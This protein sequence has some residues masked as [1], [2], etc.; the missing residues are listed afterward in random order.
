MK[1]S[2]LDL[3]PVLFII[4][5]ND[6]THPT[7][8]D[9]GMTLFAD[10]IMIYRPICTPEDLAMLQSGIDSL[11]SWTE[12]NFLLE[13][14]MGL[15]VKPMEVQ[16]LLSFLF[17]GGRKVTHCFTNVFSDVIFYPPPTAIVLGIENYSS[18]CMSCYSD[19][20]ALLLPY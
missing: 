13:H 3:G 7:L 6:I 15:Y 20:L 12:H 10:D 1:G 19:D 14:G 8:F 5:F 17:R 11:T 18:A 16:E 4:Y 9:G 2:V